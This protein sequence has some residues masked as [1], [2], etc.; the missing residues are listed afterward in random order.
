MPFA[1]G[2]GVCSCTTTGLIYVPPSRSP[3]TA[4]RVDRVTVATSSVTNHEGCVYTGNSH[5]LHTRRTTDINSRSSTTPP[6]TGI[7]QQPNPSP[8]APLTQPP[9]SAASSSSA[10]GPAPSREISEDGGRFSPTV[11]V[12]GEG[13]IAEGHRIGLGWGLVHSHGVAARAGGGG[14]LGGSFSVRCC[15]PMKRSACCQRTSACQMSAA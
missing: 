14:V 10:I 7:I 15:E 12:A 3:G 9:I 2:N 1:G 8:A 4:I 11:W 13:A 5:S 6:V